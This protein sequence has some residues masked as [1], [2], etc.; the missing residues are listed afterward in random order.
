MNQSHCGLIYPTLVNMLASF[1]Q[2]TLIVAAIHSS[3]ARSMPS[4][5]M[6]SGLFTQQA[7]ESLF[8]CC[9]Q[10]DTLDPGAF[11]TAVCNTCQISPTE[12]HPLPSLF[13][14]L[15][16]RLRHTMS[17]HRWPLWCHQRR[18][19]IQRSGFSGSIGTTLSRRPRTSSK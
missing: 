1:L 7:S 8:E 19:A 11:S 6:L 18:R 12:Q 3:A 9:P 5:F 16:Y 4:S 2:E 15:T 14:A 13:Q 17:E 10:A